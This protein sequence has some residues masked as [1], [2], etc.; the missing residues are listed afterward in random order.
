MPTELTRGAEK[1]EKKV[2]T[3]LETTP[4]SITVPTANK[5]DAAQPTPPAIA[6]HDTNSATPNPNTTVT[7]TGA[8]GAELEADPNGPEK[9][10]ADDSKDDDKLGPTWFDALLLAI[11]SGIKLSNNLAVKAITEWEKRQANKEYPSLKDLENLKTELVA[12]QERLKNLDTLETELRA[13]HKED[14]NKTTADL[15]ERLEEATAQTL[16]E[17]DAIKKDEAITPEDR[18]AIDSASEKI[19]DKLNEVQPTLDASKLT[20]TLSSAPKPPPPGASEPALETADTAPS[21]P[22]APIDTQPAAPSFPTLSS[23]PEFSSTLEKLKKD[24]EALH[25]NPTDP[26]STPEFDPEH[27]GPAQAIVH[28]DQKAIG[29]L[30]TLR[31]LAPASVPVP[32]AKDEKQTTPDEQQTT[33]TISSPKNR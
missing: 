9:K 29:R 22:A 1:A 32:Q 20:T 7:A 6:I 12:A 19:T 2:E 28:Q 25:S 16:T 26:G 5:D 27:T 30:P 18:N 17:L 13:S 15:A 10:N 3:P 33:P 14:P 8:T 21:T 23:T 4:P 31:S 24:G 11:R